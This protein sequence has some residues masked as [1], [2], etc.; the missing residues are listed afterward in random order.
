MKKKFLGLICLLYALIITFVSRYNIL[1]NFLA[2]QMHIYIK[3]TL[4]ILIIMGVVIFYD[5][6]NAYKFKISDLVLI[7]PLIMLIV[8]GDGRLTTNLSNNRNL[9]LN[10]KTST[11]ITKKD[12]SKENSLKE[13]EK[14]IKD[15]KYDFTNVDF[16]V[17]NETYYDLANY[18]TYID[19]TNKYI[20]KTIKVRGFAT[21]TGTYLPKGH[22]LLGKYG[23][24]CCAADAGLVGFIVK[25]DNHRIKD[26]SWYEIEGVFYKTK[27]YAGYDIMA[28]KIVNIK[29]INGDDEEIY[30]YPCYSYD[31]GL[32]SELSKY[33]FEY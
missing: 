14:N 29:E 3:S 27:D 23:V 7:L 8:A 6:H 1:G 11:K 32:C 12:S 4:Y 25:E 20:G 13:V 10:T 2:P 22:F 24:S 15:G 18:L 31:D 21:K 26:G 9:N 16:P 17:I 33:N 5:E 28:V 19:E 30:V